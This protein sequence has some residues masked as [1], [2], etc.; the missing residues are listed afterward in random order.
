VKGIYLDIGLLVWWKE[1][2]GGII[3][4]IIFYM[5]YSI[6]NAKNV[7]ERRYT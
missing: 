7:K 3:I 4:D 5:S 6:E 1:E 2:K